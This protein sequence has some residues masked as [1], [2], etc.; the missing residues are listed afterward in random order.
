MPHEEHEGQRG[1]GYR[2][3]SPSDPRYRRPDDR[4]PVKNTGTEGDY[5]NAKPP[6]HDLRAEEA[7]LG[8]AM[9]TDVGKT[10]LVEGVTPADFYRPSH[11]TIAAAIIGLHERGEPVD[12]VTVAGELTRRGLLDT[13]KDGPATLLSLVAGVPATSSAPAYATLVHD[14]ATLRRLAGAAAE[15]RDV[16]YAGGDAHQAVIAAQGYLDAVA[17]QNGTRTYSGLDVVDLS[18][19]DVEDLEEPELLLRSDGKGLLYAG[20]MHAFVAEPSTGKSW[21]ALQAAIE[22]LGWG[23]SVVYL[24]FEDTFRGIRRRLSALGLDAGD[25]ERFRYVA[26]SGGLGG[27]ELRQLFDLVDTLEPE[28]VVIDGVAE[29]LARDGY[30]EDRNRDVVE[31]TEKLPRPLS[32]MGPAVVMIDHVSKKKDERGRGGRGAGHKLAAVDGAVYTVT[33]AKAFSRETTGAVRLRIDKDRPGGVGG[34]GEEAAVVNL[35]PT[36][37]GRHFEV[38]ILAPG[39]LSPTAVTRPS[40]AMRDLSRA[41]EDQGG[42]Y[43]KSGLPALVAGG[44]RKTTIE[45]A[46]GYLVADGYA[47]ETTRSGDRRTYLRLVKPYVEGVDPPGPPPD[48]QETLELD[49]ADE[50][51]PF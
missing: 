1:A 51:G 10:A 33:L 22:V 8:A 40:H 48:D 30:D 16:A 9:L 15:V 21:L 34:I 44:Y 50:L 29:A 39:E 20:K 4:R 47:I 19:V 27:P 43:A 3:G 25:L 28:L 24:D 12:P 42:E 6:P 11:G 5:A 37:H 46:I 23:G 26:P 38:E 49:Q 7:L 17:S 31:W 14:A 35:K 18:T 45:K 2:D 41:L 32:K 36:D 13:L